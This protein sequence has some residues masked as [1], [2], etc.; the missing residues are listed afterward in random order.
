MCLS[1]T[2]SWPPGLPWWLRWHRVRLQR[3][4]HGVNPWAKRS[5]WGRD[6]LLTLGCLLA[7]FH[8]QR[9]SAGY[10]PWDH[11]ELD[12]NEWLAFSL[13]FS[14]LLINGLWMTESALLTPLLWI[15]EGGGRLQRREEEVEASW[16]K[17][18]DTG[19]LV[20]TSWFCSVLNFWVFSFIVC[21]MS[22]VE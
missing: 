10:R 19:I 22:S 16:F 9:N 4:R 17:E 2:E 15:E 21:P 20:H 3:R 13:F 12:M 7:E 1:Q 14:L 5:P 18:R 6:W 11:K 8:G